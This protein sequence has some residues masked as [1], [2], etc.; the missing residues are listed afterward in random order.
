MP[1][2][3]IRH[4]GLAIIDRGRTQNQI[5]TNSNYVSAYCSGQN[6]P[7]SIG[8]G[9]GVQ[10]FSYYLLVAKGPAC[11]YADHGLYDCQVLR[12]RTL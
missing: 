4:P 11:K 6:T 2:G 3:Y 7:G 9:L 5:H 8:G 12:S 10:G 1:V